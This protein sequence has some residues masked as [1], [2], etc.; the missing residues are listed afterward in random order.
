MEKK[1]R[2]YEKYLNI[3]KLDVE[4][5]K[6]NNNRCLE[7][8]GSMSFIIGNTVSMSE[9]SLD[10]L[11]QKQQVTMNNIAN[12]D[13]PGYKSKYVT[14]EEEFSNKLKA[15]SMTGNRQEISN[16]IHEAG[17]TVRNTNPE[18]ARLDGNDVNTDTENVELA[19]TTL[20]YQYLLNS[21]NSDIARYRTVIKG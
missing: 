9:K 1:I 14:F 3:T 11:W 8:S 12:I 2:L 10:F 18:S 15:A 5:N 7:W 17:T 13:T 21:V 19:R 20:Q 16:I 4:Y 6:Y